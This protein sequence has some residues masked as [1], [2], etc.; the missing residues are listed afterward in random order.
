MDRD[1]KLEADLH[2]PRLRD[3]SGA[4]HHRNRGPLLREFNNAVSLVESKLLGAKLDSRRRLGEL[5]E[6]ER[7]QTGG[8]TMACIDRRT[9]AEHLSHGPVGRR[10]T[11][12]ALARRPDGV[13]H[14]G[15]W[16]KDE[17]HGRAQRSRS[18]REL[19]PPPPTIVSWAGPGRASAETIM[20][21]HLDLMGRHQFRFQQ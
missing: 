15:Q 11:E 21:A 5:V 8:N 4:T 20:K 19:I 3:R 17:L 6:V 18:R 7:P 2:S 13:G 14:G 12:P 16:P 9:E 1:S 10:A